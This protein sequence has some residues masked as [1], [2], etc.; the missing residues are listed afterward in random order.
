MIEKIIQIQNIGR[1]ADY[2]VDST[3]E[4]NGQFRKINIIYAP[5][6]SGKTTISTIFKSLKLNKGAFIEYKKSSSNGE[7]AYVSIKSNSISQPIEYKNQRWNNF[8]P[9]VEIFD[10]HF[11]EENLYAGSQLN[12]QNKENL[13]K[14]LLG[15]KGIQYKNKCKSIIKKK[16]KVIDELQKANKGNIEPAIKMHRINLEFIQVTL[17]NALREYREYSESIFNKHIET[18][19]TFLTKFTSYI[20]LIEFSYE[21]GASDSAIF[22]IFIVFEIHGRR[23]QF[24]APNLSKTIGDA[25]YTMSEGDKSAIA[26]CFFLARLDILDYTDK[27]IVFDDPLSSFDYGRKTTTVFNLAKIATQ[28]EQFFLLTH[29]IYFARE[30]SEKMNFTEILN[31]K[32][33]DNGKSRVI[34]FHDIYAET[35]NGLQKDLQTVKNYLSNGAKTDIE[36]REV[37][38]CI[39]PIL[40][41]IIKIKYFDCLPNNCWLGDIISLINKSTSRTSILKKVYSELIELNDFTK[42]Y[43]HSSNISGNELINPNELRNYVKILMSVVDEI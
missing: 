13:F 33:Y 6:G 32:I 39:R 29:D 36:R 22:M 7:E 30:F 15:N 10:I 3:K 21:K 25:K 27:I 8:I 16:E 18:I 4:W 35:L 2:K 38:R 23:V 42:Q 26:F 1:F 40:E 9:N 17:D 31:L 14:L 5:N 34:G 12:K 20:R 43:H 24:N 41:G 11:I 19:N 28:S 37:I